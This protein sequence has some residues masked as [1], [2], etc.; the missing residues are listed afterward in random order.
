MPWTAANGSKLTECLNK[1]EDT[2]FVMYVFHMCTVNVKM[3]EAWEE[4]N[5]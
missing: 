1:R 3:F 4:E 5:R 2:S